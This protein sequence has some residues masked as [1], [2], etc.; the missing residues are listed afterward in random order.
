MNILV[1]ARED[2]EFVG[3]E[4][5]KTLALDDHMRGFVPLPSKEDIGEVNL[6][7]DRGQTRAND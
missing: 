1:G 2:L 7:R 3:F 6:D 5:V 4:K